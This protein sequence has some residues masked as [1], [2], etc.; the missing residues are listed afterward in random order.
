MQIEVDGKKYNLVP[1]EEEVDTLLE[2][3]KIPQ[4]SGDRGSV[5]KIKEAT[6]EVS[7]YRE[8]YKARKV[9]VQE[10]TAPPKRYSKLDKTGPML[11]GYEYRGEKLFVG[12]GLV[13]E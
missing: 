3:Y 6:S 10:V 5:G 12:E 13:E 1:V 2:E 9:Q 11:E 4:A 8:R 7:D